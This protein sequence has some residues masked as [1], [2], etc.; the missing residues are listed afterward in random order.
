[1]QGYDT[2][3]I[4]IT[5]V[6]SNT[7]ACD[8]APTHAALLAGCAEEAVH[9]ILTKLPL[10]VYT[11]CKVNNHTIATATA[12]KA[13]GDYQHAQT[14]SRTHKV[15]S[16]ARQGREHNMEGRAIRKPRVR[17]TPCRTG[18]LPVGR[19]KCHRRCRRRRRTTTNAH[20]SQTDWKMRGTCTRQAC[21][22]PSQNT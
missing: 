10:E 19:D 20:L 4:T 15:R 6:Y 12:H 21:A 2:A 17:S 11:A 7:V 16:S 3:T 8:G 22:H 18:A 5:V 13:A 9:L 1:M 14:C